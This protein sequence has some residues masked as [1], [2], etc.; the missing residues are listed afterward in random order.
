MAVISTPLT[1]VK[2]ARPAPLHLYNE[3]YKVCGKMVCIEPKQ[4]QRALGNKATTIRWVEEAN[5]LI[6]YYERRT[7]PAYSGALVSQ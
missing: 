6:D 1:E 3:T 5:A 2:P 4:A 7:N